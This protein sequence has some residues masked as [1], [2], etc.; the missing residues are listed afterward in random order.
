MKRLATPMW[1]WGKFYERI[2]RDFLQGN[3]D[4]AREAKE[5][6]AI[7]YW[8]GISS[9]IIDLIMSDELPRGLTTLTNI[10][11]GRTV[12]GRSDHYELSGRRCDRIHTGQLGTDRR[13]EGEDRASDKDHTGRNYDRLIV[14]RRMMK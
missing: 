2:I 11:R 8:W 1:N 6:P 5:K 3:W 12:S 10:V 13:R 7:N 14:F 9:G 4:S